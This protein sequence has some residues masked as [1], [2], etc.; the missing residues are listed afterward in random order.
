[1]AARHPDIICA[2]E[3]GFM[4]RL[5][6]VSVERLSWM[7]RGDNTCSY[8]VRGDSATVPSPPRRPPEPAPPALRPAL[9]D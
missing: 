8:R 6:G 3:L 9:P 5:L 2:A 1:V 7:A 4:R